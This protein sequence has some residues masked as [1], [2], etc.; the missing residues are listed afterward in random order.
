M[1]LRRNFLVRW[2]PRDGS[3][4]RKILACKALETEEG[5][6]GL[7]PHDLVWILVIP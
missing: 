3:Q 5:A 6:L 1:L 4:V 7:F 2:N